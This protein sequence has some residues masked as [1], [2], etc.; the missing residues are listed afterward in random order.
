[1]EKIYAT[2]EQ[3]KELH[4]KDDLEQI[5]FNLG[6]YYNKFLEGDCS[7]TIEEIIELKKVSE[8]LREVEEFMLEIYKKH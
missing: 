2:L 6:Y 5:V 7:P 8:K 1:M 3:I 4:S